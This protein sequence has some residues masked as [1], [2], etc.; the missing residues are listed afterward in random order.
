MAETQLRYRFEQSPRKKGRCPNCGEPGEFRFYQDIITGQRLDELYGRCERLNHCNY[1]NPPLNI[2]FET[3]NLFN[4]PKS[5]P[6]KYVDTQI[7]DKTLQFYDRNNFA[8]YLERKFGLQKTVNAVRKYKFGTGRNLSTI[9]W[10]IDLNYLVRTGKKILFDCNG[11]RDKSFTIY[12]VFQS[13]EGYKPCLFGEQ[14]LKGAQTDTVIGLVES[15]KT[16]IVC[17]MIRPDI[18]WLATGGANALTA[19]K[20]MVL[21]KRKVLM[22]P[23]FDSAG[24]NAFQGKKDML[25]ILGCR[26]S[27]LDILPQVNNGMDIADIILDDINNM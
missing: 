4:P 18:I 21:K 1:F 15:E 19:E 24:R 13:S 10:Y 6:I 27:L 22:V 26:I 14:L 9:F 7:A 11:H 20:A 3:Q 5:I 2:P 16:A 25:E 8:L 17:S 12:Y 23:D